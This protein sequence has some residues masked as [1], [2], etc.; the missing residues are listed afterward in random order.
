VS[1]RGTGVLGL[2]YGYGPYQVGP[3]SGYLVGGTA[4][5]V[6]A[7]ALVALVI[8][9]RTGAVNWRSWAAVASLAA[10]GAVG[11]GGW[12]IVTSGGVG[13]NIGGGLVLLF[14]PAMIA[15]L[16]MVTALLSGDGAPQTKR[17][18]RLLIVAAVL[19]APA[20]Y[21]GLFA[22]GR[23]DAGAGFINAT[24]YADVRIGQTRPA[25]HERLGREGDDLT[26]I[27]FGPARPGLLC[28]FYSELDGN[29][30]YQFCY[31]A[32]VL[33]SKDNSRY[34]SGG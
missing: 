8:R 18:T 13:A 22:L 2:D 1:F 3:A 28:E 7:A 16:L 21:V 6:A 33:V 10:A 26:N 25:V 23:Y 9:T 31:R 30:A 24:Q 20:L 12:R 15:L 11:A 14:G 19:V 4:A 32:G 34:S 27:L 17:R 29:H 5:V